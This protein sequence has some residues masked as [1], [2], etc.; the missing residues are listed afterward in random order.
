M[1]LQPGDITQNYDSKSIDI[2]VL[3]VTYFCN[4]SDTHSTSGGTF[5]EPITAFRT[6]TERVSVSP[7]MK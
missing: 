7:Q 5:G 1:Q 3:H 4:E 6:W 2:M